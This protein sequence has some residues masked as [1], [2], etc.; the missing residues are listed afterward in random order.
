MSILSEFK[1]DITDKGLFPDS[2]K[3]WKSFCEKLAKE[4]RSETTHHPEVDPQ[5]MEAINDLGVALMEALNARG[6]AD[7]ETKLSVIPV[8]L[9]N[10]QNYA[11][12][13]SLCFS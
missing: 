4:G 5:T 12:Q 3:N 13:W 10:K 1:V 9:R 11:I 7:Y 2:A 6:T 8:E